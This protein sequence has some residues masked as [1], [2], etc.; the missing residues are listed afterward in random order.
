MK[1]VDLLAWV[2]ERVTT[3]IYA[4]TKVCKLDFIEPYLS[5]NPWSEALKD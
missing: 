5:K 4:K 2:K 3:K 1:R